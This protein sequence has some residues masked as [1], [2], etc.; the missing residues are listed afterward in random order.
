MPGRM[1]IWR[2]LFVF[3]SW[4]CFGQFLV[5]RNRTGAA[6][7][8]G[9]PCPMIAAGHRAT[10]IQPASGDRKARSMMSLYFAHSCREVSMQIFGMSR[11]A[12]SRSVSARYSR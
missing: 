7:G 2:V 1:I 4:Q 11:A 3:G 5:R 8:R 12:N 6:G 9:G 10:C